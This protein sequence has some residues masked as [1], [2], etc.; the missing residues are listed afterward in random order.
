M[1]QATRRRYPIG[2][3]AFEEILKLDASAD[4]ALRQIESRGYLVP[5]ETDGRKLV[6]VGVS[7][8]SAMRKVSEWKSVEMP[9]DESVGGGIESF[10]SEGN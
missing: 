4:E 8:D 1:E 10:Q 6:K 5:Y 7:F 9:C 3:H 2:V